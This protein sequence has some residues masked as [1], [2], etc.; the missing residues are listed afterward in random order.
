[1]ILLEFYL[2]CEYMISYYRKQLHAS[3]E[4]FFL[5][6]LNKINIKIDQSVKKFYL[7]FVNK[8]MISYTWK[9]SKFY[10][11]TI[12]VCMITDSTFMLNKSEINLSFTNRINVSYKS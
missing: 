5:F 8:K 10:L 6:I 4:H 12:I 2:I 3:T 9:L 1:M 7:W 11:E